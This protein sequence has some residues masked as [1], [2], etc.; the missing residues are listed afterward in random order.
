MAPLIQSPC[1]SNT[2]QNDAGAYVANPT[3]TGKAN[4][5][6]VSKYQHGQS[7][8]DGNTEFQFKAGDLNF[9]SSSYEWLFAL[10][11]T[12]PTINM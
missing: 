8:P 10:S 12:K 9:H 2:A 11:E 5:G 7:T 3:L 1:S 6:F 4:F